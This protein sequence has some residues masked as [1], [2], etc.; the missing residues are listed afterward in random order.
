K[1]M[2]VMSGLLSAH[3]KAQA[4]GMFW[5]PNTWDLSISFAVA[6]TKASP[7]VIHCFDTAPASN[8]TFD[9]AVFSRLVPVGVTLGVTLISGSCHA[10]GSPF[11]RGSEKPTKLPPAVQ[12]LSKQPEGGGLML[13]RAC[14]WHHTSELDGPGRSDAARRSWHCATQTPAGSAGVEWPQST[15]TGRPLGKL[16]SNSTFSGPP[17]QWASASAE[18]ANPTLKPVCPVVKAI[19]AAGKATPDSPAGAPLS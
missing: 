2:S 9:P 12:A 7:C 18:K 10:T 13:G 16:P 17:L 15:H 5:N 6:S 11:T 19:A 14:A 1:S 4:A 3:G 8:P